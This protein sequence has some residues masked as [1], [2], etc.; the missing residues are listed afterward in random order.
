MKIDHS[1]A[2]EHDKFRELAALAHSGMLTEGEEA[3][4]I[5]HLKTC[6]SCREVR[7]QYAILATEGIPYL[8][9]GQSII[10]SAQAD[11]DDVATRKALF[12]RI[13]AQPVSSNPT[14]Q[15]RSRR[16]HWW[17]IQSPW[18]HVLRAVLTGALLA[19][20]GLVGYRVGSPE[21]KRP[22]LHN[23]SSE[24]LPQNLNG[25]TR[26]VVG[27]IARPSDSTKQISE[28]QQLVSQREIELAEL[29]LEMQTL[30]NRA[31]D[32][33][34]TNLV[35]DQKLRAALHQREALSIQ[36]SNVEK[37]YNNLQAELTTLRS[38]RDA[39]LLHSASLES[40]LGELNAAA[41]D[42][43]RRRQNDE[44]YLASDRDL[45]ELIGARK[46]YIADVFDVD[47]HSRTRRPF[48]R[49]FYTLGKSLIFYVFDLDTV[50]DRKK[51]SAF[52]VWGRKEATDK[53]MN[54][55]ILYMDNESNRRWTLRFDDPQEL[56]EIDRVFVTVEP[57]GGSQK[58]TG[59]PFLYALLRQEPNHP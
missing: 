48:G 31:K 56:A 39:A 22:S 28:L 13:E 12:A 46:L 27:E 41:H 54:L 47:S 37:E 35:T 51:A 19:A 17:Q 15:W 26:P 24:N 30:T 33:A 40:K 45:R 2:N 43:E 25:Q 32:L 18:Q 5:C 49:V 57:N 10:E 23:G 59:K 16:S 20:V 7:D 55:G 34:A 9:A 3:E 6:D 14:F 58:P 1:I 21:Q 8:L 53:V 52:Q 50:P 11:W 29:R 38:E 36:L 42:N 44:Q 4:L